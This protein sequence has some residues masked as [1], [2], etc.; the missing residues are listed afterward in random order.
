MG[1]PSFGDISNHDLTEY[2]LGSIPSLVHAESEPCDVIRLS[3]LVKELRQLH[4]IH[5]VYSIPVHPEA[6]IVEISQSVLAYFTEYGDDALRLE[7]TSDILPTIEAAYHMFKMYAQYIDD[8][9]TIVRVFS[10][11]DE[12]Q[13]TVSMIDALS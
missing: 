1:S 12:G 13:F 7:A 3:R 5:D 8:K 11:K 6:N 2:L 10:D 4:R 9:S